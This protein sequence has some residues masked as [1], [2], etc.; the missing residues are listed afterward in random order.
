MEQDNSRS[1]FAGQ[2]STL[3][4]IPICGTFLERMQA[5]LMLGLGAL[6]LQRGGVGT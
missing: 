6:G 5:G 1:R 4:Q 3:P 2:V